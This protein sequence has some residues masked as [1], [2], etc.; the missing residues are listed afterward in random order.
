M[1]S[2]RTTSTRGRL[3]IALTSISVVLVAAGPSLA[4]LGLV[5]PINGFN[6]FLTGLGLGIAS[7]VL[8]LSS[9]LGERKKKNLRR[10]W[11]AI[12]SVLAFFITIL[13]LTVSITKGFRT[14]PKDC[15]S[16]SSCFLAGV[17]AFYAIAYRPG[18]FASE[19]SKEFSFLTDISTNTGS[20]PAFSVGPRRGG[21]WNFSEEKIERHE[22]AYGDTTTFFAGGVPAE[23]FPIVLG[24]AEEKNWTIQIQRPDFYTFEATA[25]TGVFRFKDDISV[26]MYNSP[27][28]PTPKH[29]RC[30][31]TAIEVRSRSRTGKSDFGRNAARIENFRA[32]IRAL[33]VETEY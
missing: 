16:F 25:E 15:D 19:V 26:K 21:D 5:P 8:G 10:G 4:H 29:S 23:N 17:D 3:T 32:R 22:F 18:E 7:F 6:V 31:S 20:P 2:T 27:R 9:L 24:V 28:C 11:T 1:T 33:T 14:S 12:T 13:F 30:S